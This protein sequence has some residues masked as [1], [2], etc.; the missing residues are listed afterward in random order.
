MKNLTDQLENISEKTGQ[1]VAWMTLIM[2]IIAFAVVVLRYLFD[3]GWIALQEI[4]TYLH[5]FIF[6]LGAAYTLKH[7]G[8]VRVDIFYRKMTPRN[9]ALV[10][11]VG[12]VL[13]LLPVCLFILWTSWDYVLSSWLLLEGSQEADGLPLVFILKTSILLMSLLLI[14]QGIALLLRAIL[15]LQ[16]TSAGGEHG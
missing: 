10:D 7:E 15:R 2:V 13:L 4:V 9:K 11:A 1:A 5:S 6:M 12:T 16:E 3:T 8:H 14:L